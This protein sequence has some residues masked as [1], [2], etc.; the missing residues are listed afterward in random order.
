MRIY[1]LIIVLIF[2]LQPVFG[3]R[4]TKLNTNGKGTLFGQF[5]YNRSAYTRPD[6]SFES[7][8]YK[9]T[10]ENVGL[11]DNEE[12]K[13]MGKYFSDSSPQFSAKI[14]YFIANK[15]AI[16]LSYDRYNTFFKDQ[17]EVGLKGTFAPGSNSLYSGSVNETILLDRN[18]Y[19]LTQ[20]QGIDYISIGIQ[21]N[22]M[23]G[24]TKKS[25][26]ALSTLYGIKGGI[27]LSN[28]ESTYDSSTSQGSTSVSGFGL[29]MNVGIQMDF[30]QYIYLQLGLNGGLLSQA[31]LKLATTGNY[32]AKQVVGYLSPTISLGFNIF[33]NPK[34]NC[35]TCPQ[36]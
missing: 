35:G 7:N 15:W 18:Q 21:R 8:N 6:V 23:L 1:V 3:Q 34:N 2:S 9:F 20:K 10:L 19:N 16:T 5:G 33:A 36:W 31:K 14:G 22:D 25:E 26:F 13:S 4:K 17:Q 11:S 27:L 30:Y 29:T 28:P 12:G 32:T 24:R